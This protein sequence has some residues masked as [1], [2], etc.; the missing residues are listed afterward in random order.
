MTFSS[1]DQLLSLASSSNTAGR[2]RC[3]ASSSSGAAEMRHALASRSLPLTVIRS[4]RA[5][6]RDQENLAAVAGPSAVDGPGSG[7]VLAH[8]AP[9]VALATTAS[10]R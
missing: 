8:A 1:A 10:S 4:P 9:P 6:V 3:K 5:V 7:C 2:A